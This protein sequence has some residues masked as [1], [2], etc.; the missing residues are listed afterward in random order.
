M[1]I[2]DDNDD[3]TNGDDNDD[4][5]GDNRQ[6]IT[7][8]MVT[9]IMTAYDG[10]QRSKRMIRV[11]GSND[12]ADDDKDGDKDYDAGHENI[13]ITNSLSHPTNF[14]LPLATS[15]RMTSTRTSRRM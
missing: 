6:W 9:T 3:D 2:N 15:I 8:A 12:N 14:S 4:N 10:T 7:L 5:S 1:I 11:G 13:I